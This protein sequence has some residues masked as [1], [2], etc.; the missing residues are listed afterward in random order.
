MVLTYSALNSHTSLSVM[1]PTTVSSLRSLNSGSWPP[2]FGAAAEM[3]SAYSL[4][5]IVS[6]CL[7]T[8]A[9]LSST[10]LSITPAKQCSKSQA[11]ATSHSLA[12]WVV[13]SS[14]TEVEEVRKSSFVVIRMTRVSKSA[15]WTQSSER[16]R[17]I[18][19]YLS[20]LGV[21]YNPGACSGR[22]WKRSGSVTDSMTVGWTF[23]IPVSPVTTADLRLSAFHPLKDRREDSNPQNVRVVVVRLFL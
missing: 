17:R 6:K 7:T 20:R 14:A 4:G 11:Y 23:E 21:S 18:E 13:C 22:A 15:G 16:D 5:T 2:S 1:R 3:Q 12:S 19:R 10:F 9:C 8:S